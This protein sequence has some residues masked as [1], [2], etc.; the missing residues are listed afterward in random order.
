MRMVQKQLPAMFCA[1]ALS[2][3]KD[4][5][6]DSLNVGSQATNAPRVV[7]S[8]T[9]AVASSSPTL[10]APPEPTLNPCE[11][12]T[13]RFSLAARHRHN[14]GRL[15][16]GKGLRCEDGVCGNGTVDHDGFRGVGFL[17]NGPGAYFHFQFGST[18]RR[19]IS[20]ETL[21]LAATSDAN[22]VQRCEPF[23]KGKLEGMTVILDNRC[24]E[25]RM[26]ILDDAYEARALKNAPQ[27]PCIEADPAHDVA[28]ILRCSGNL[29]F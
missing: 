29:G 25:Y 28:P 11:V 9:S 10:D 19:R 4:H 23:S 15:T 22:G 5:T 16:W 17:E 12:L 26:T 2:A 1:M 8:V 14:P 20:C 18:I 6:V 3:C 13:D 27:D 24:T 7:H 21:G